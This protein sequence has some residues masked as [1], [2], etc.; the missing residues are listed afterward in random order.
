MDSQSSNSLYQPAMRDRRREHDS[1]CRR[2]DTV[3]DDAEGIHINYIQLL[4]R[5]RMLWIVDIPMEFA[6][7]EKESFNKIFECRDPQF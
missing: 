6:W 1:D 3:I 5:Q 7:N 4:K 2:V